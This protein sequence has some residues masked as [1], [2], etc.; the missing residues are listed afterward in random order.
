M[1]TVARLNMSMYGTRDAGRNWEDKYV[2]V[3]TQMGLE[4][5]VAVPASFWHKA[6]GIRVA[7]HGD[8]FMASGKASML[9]WLKD[10]MAKTLEIKT[11]IIGPNADQGKEM[12]ILNRKLKWEKDGITWE[13][14]GKLIEGIMRDLKMEDAKGVAA[15]CLEGIKEHM[16]KR[17]ESKMLEKEETTRYRSIG[18]MQLF[19]SG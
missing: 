1:D 12:V 6:K 18:K 11:N 9:R 4:R 19:G 7:V 14:D 17:E 5:C 3:L 15:P 16:V 13:P 8:D 2:S 10:G